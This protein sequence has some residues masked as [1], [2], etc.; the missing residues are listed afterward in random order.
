MT[1]YFYDK[2]GMYIDWDQLKKLPNID[3]LIDIG[4][5]PTGTPQLYD[6]FPAAKLLLVDPLV[7]SED[8]IRKNLLSR[9]VIFHNCGVGAEDGEVTICVEREI[10]NSHI[11]EVA[12]FNFKSDP[13]ENRKIQLRTLDSIINAETNLGKLGIKIDT[14]GYELNVILGATET[15][16]SAEFVL[17]EV[18][19]NHDSFQGMY[20]LHEFMSAMHDSGFVLSMI[21]TAKPFI[22][23]FCFQ[24]K[25]RL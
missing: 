5:G 4:V 8:F 18:R 2:T 21:M 12:D 22:A 10:T 13:L 20:K 24:P 3:T 7:E 6:R 1:K 9:N 16:K 11:L 19:H 17:A 25:N 15:L 23:D 14:E